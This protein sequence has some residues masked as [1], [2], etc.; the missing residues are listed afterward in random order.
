MKKLSQIAEG[1]F[2][3][4]ENSTLEYYIR[5]K[6]SKRI[7]GRI[8]LMCF[9]IKHERYAHGDLYPKKDTKVKIYKP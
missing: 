2:V 6:A 3:Q 4:L 8:H 1:T 9:T 7:A 5:G